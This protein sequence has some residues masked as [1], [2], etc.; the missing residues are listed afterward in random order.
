MAQDLHPQDAPDSSPIAQVPRRIAVGV[1]GSSTGDDAAAPG[2]A[3]AQAAE[4]ELILVP[5]HPDPIALLPPELDWKGVHEQARRI[6]AKTRRTL[7]PPDRTRR[8]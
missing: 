8:D 7:A 3:L 5:V 1:D 4:A 2:A 6:L